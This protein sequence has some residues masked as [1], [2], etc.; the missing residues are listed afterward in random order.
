MATTRR[1]HRFLPEIDEDLFRRSTDGERY[2]FPLVTRGP[3]FRASDDDAARLTRR[4]RISANVFAFVGFAI[5]TSMRWVHWLAW[6]TPAL[7]ATGLVT[8][9]VVARGLPR[10]E[11]V[12]LERTATLDED[13]KRGTMR[14]MAAVIGVIG[15]V[16]T[17]VLLSDRAMISSAIVLVPLS[18][19]AITALYLWG[20]RK[21]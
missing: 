15:V 14:G 19:F 2:W 21:P 10:V 12:S 8:R 4:W 16:T 6:L 3:G 9:W 17:A 1:R 18:F 20:S 11:R 5:A 13:F 7:I